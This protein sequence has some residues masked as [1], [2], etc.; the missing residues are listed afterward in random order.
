MV[1]FECMTPSDSTASATHNYVCV[2]GFSHEPAKKK[3]LRFE[4]GDTVIGLSK[5]DLASLEKRGA[6]TVEDS[7]NG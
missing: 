3:P 7:S 5:K 1:V 2:I 4:P 6:V